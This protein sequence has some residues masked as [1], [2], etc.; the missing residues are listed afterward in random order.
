MH[1]K[2]AIQNRRSI[3]PQTYTD[4]KIPKE[5]IEDIVAQTNYAP[6]HRKTE[7][8]RFKII[9]NQKRVELGTLLAKWYKDN[10]PSEK[11]SERKYN[12]TAQKPA[13]CSHVIAICMQRDPKESV[14]E[15]EE[16][17]AVAMAVQNMWLMAHSHGVG[18][19]WSSPKSIHSKACQDFLGLKEGESCLG[20][21]YMGY[22]NVPTIE[23]Q[24][25][26]IAD[27]IDWLG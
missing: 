14:P 8:W 7:P 15:W 18:A 17:A 27:K 3:F 16:V 23:A 9:S 13:K 21:F 20:F 4:Q 10:T 24:R 11:F 12:K 2:E 26:P 1:I 22:H 19:Y 5:I 25:K 6:T